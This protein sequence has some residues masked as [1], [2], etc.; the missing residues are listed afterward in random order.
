MEITLIDIFKQL[1]SVITNNP[2][3]DQIVAALL[4]L[5]FTSL[6]T[7]IYKNRN[8]IKRRRKSDYYIH[9]VG[10]KTHDKPSVKSHV[11]TLGRRHNI[12]NSQPLVYNEMLPC[13]CLAKDKIII[14]FCM[15][16]LLQYCVYNGPLPEG[17]YISDE[18][19]FDF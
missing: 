4:I 1:S 7:Y 2:I 12:F 10:R 13:G 9:A 15:K 14:K 6:S 16:D 5:I 8:K 11:T 17:Y 3:F 19:V 18:T